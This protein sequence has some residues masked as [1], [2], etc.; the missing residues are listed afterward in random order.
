MSMPI[1]GLIL[2]DTCDKRY[3]LMT[4]VKKLFSFQEAHNSTWFKNSIKK[5]IKWFFFFR[6]KKSLKQ[7]FSHKKCDKYVNYDLM[8]R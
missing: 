3:D 4:H 7:Y 2:H 1:K 5:M 6:K 8:Q